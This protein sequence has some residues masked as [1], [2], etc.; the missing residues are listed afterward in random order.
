MY[1][2][3]LH[4]PLSFDLGGDYLDPDTRALLRGV[5]MPLVETQ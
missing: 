1:R 5:S 2:R 4:E 3:V